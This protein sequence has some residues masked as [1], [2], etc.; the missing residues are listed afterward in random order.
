VISTFSKGYTLEDHRYVYMVET[1]LS[2]LLYRLRHDTI[3]PKCPIL[4]NHLEILKRMAPYIFVTPASFNLA[5]P[6][7]SLFKAQAV[8]NMASNLHRLNAPEMAQDHRHNIRA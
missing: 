6:K 7:G 8:S 1:Q 3:V 2:S 5:V 4:C